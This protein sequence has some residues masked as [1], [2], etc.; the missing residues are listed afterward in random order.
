MVDIPGWRQAWESA[1]V[2]DYFQAFLASGPTGVFTT[3][4]VRRR[5]LSVLELERDTDYGGTTLTLL[6]RSDLE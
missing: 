4:K 6:T 3:R 1:G 2:G 5:Q